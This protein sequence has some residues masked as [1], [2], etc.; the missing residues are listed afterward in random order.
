MNNWCKYYINPNILYPNI[1]NFCFLFKWQLP[2]ARNRPELGAHRYRGPFVTDHQYFASHEAV[3]KKLNIQKLN[4]LLPF[5]FVP[6]L[7]HENSMCSPWNVYYFFLGNISEL[8][9]IIEDCS[10][11]GV[12]LVRDMEEALIEKGLYPHIDLETEESNAGI[13]LLENGL[14]DIAATS[15]AQG[16][17]YMCPLLHQGKLFIR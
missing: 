2:Q 13:I 9:N 1:L 8:Q 6:H 10:E 7:S 15:I 14:L 16:F 3:G 5:A 4:T 17:F 12:N 11:F